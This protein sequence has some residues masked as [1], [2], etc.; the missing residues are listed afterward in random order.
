MAPVELHVDALSKVDVFVHPSA[1]P[2]STQVGDLLTIRPLTTPSRKNKGKDRALLF[3]VDRFSDSAAP[4]SAGAATNIGANADT[5]AAQGQGSAQHSTTAATAAAASQGDRERR[6]PPKAQVLVSQSVQKT[7]KWIKPRTEVVVEV[8]SR[9]DRNHQLTPPPP[10][11]LVA[12]HVEL[13]FNNF[14]LSRPDMFRLTLGLARTCLF[15]NQRVTSEVLIGARLRVGAIFNLNNHHL[16]SAYITDETKIIF[17]SESARCF[18]FVEI[19]QEM[20]HFEEDGSMLRERCEV[21]LD[22]VFQHWSG[23]QR[24]G[25]GG[26]KNRGYSTSHTVSIILYGRVIYE[27]NGEGEEA[28]APMKRHENGTLYRDFFKVIMDLTPSPHPSIVRTVAQEIQRW[29]ES[30]LLRTRATGEQKLAGRIAY[31]HES[32]VLEATNLALNSFEEHW[33]DRDLQRTGLEVLVLTAGT[34]YYEVPKRLLRLTTERMLYHGIGL[35]LISLSKTPL[36]TV[37]LFAFQSHEPG[38]SDEP[39]IAFNGFKGKRR[40]GTDIQPTNVG[41]PSSH[42][43]THS[44]TSGPYTTATAEHSGS[45]H[46]TPQNP[47][48]RDPTRIALPNNQKDPL[49]YD[50]SRPFQET[51]IYYAEPMFIFCSFFGLQV[52]KPHRID[53]FMP[54]A[55]CYELFSQGIGE[56]TPI[57]IPLLPPI[58]A[59]MDAEDGGTGANGEPVGYL[60]EWEKRQAKREM[61]DAMAVGARDGLED[62]STWSKESGA[63]STTTE[64]SVE[65][66]NNAGGSWDKTIGAKIKGAHSNSDATTESGSDGSGRGG[67]SLSAQS[68]R[69]M[70][71]RAAE[72]AKVHDG[73]MKRVTLERKREQE[74]V[75]EK[76]RGRQQR[77]SEAE[78]VATSSRSKTPMPGRP[79]SASVATS[80]RTVS[81]AQTKTDRNK[82]ATPALIARLTNTIATPSSSGSST[83]QSFH[84]SR[85]GWLGLFR[86]PASTSNATPAPS[87][88]VQRVEAQANV[89][90][91]FDLDTDM[92]VTS[93]RSDHGTTSPPPSNRT[94]L[95]TSPQI[96]GP[97]LPISIKTRA[98]QP[99][100]AD[101]P[102]RGLRNSPS[103]KHFT[104]TGISKGK[105]SGHRSTAFRFNPSKPGRRSNGLADQARRWASIFVRHANDQRSVNWVSITRGACLPLT[106]D[107]LPTADALATEYSD[108]GYTV[109]TS[110]T[111][112]S[113]LLLSEQG[114]TGR[115]VVAELVLE[116][117]SQ[118]LSH[119]FQL[120]TP[121]NHIGALDEINVASSKTLPDVLHEVDIGDSTAV[122]L[123]LAN[124]IHRIWYDRRT[125]AVHVKIMRR[126]R[127]W[128]KESYNFSGLIF[129]QGSNVYRYTELEFPYPSMIEP[130]DW[131]HLDRLVAGAERPDLRPSLRFWRTRLVLLPAETVN[132]RESIIRTTEALEADASDAM[133]NDQ[134]FYTFRDLIESARWI[135]PGADREQIPIS[136]T[137]LTAPEW[138][139]MMANN[140]TSANPDLLATAVN[141]AAHSSQSAN[142]HIPRLS[143]WLSRLT[144]T[145]ETPPPASPLFD[146]DMQLPSPISAPE[147]L[148][149]MGTSAPSPTPK[150]PV[151]QMSYAVIVDLDHLGKKSSR[152]E[153]VICH[154]DRSHNRNA[155]YHLE[156]NWLSG[157]GKIIDSAI[158]AWSRQVQKFGLRLIEVSTRAVED[159][160]NPFQSTTILPFKVPPPPIVDSTLP[161]EYYEAGLLRSLGFFLDIGADSSF[162]SDVD[163][164]YSYKRSP[165]PRSQYIHRSGTVLVAILGDRRGL[166]IVA[167]RIYLSHRP[168]AKD[169]DPTQELV[170]LCGDLQKL[171]A[172]WDQLG[173]EADRLKEKAASE[174]ATA[175]EV[176]QE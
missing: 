48:G 80:V 144:N 103:L 162:P 140:A 10:D 29:H 41:L 97:T 174:A 168:Q 52:D 62:L 139:S 102:S 94:S 125:Q 115:N 24:K 143:T 122:Y 39:H 16:R 132:E 77:I 65:L 51:S 156:L 53:R 20:W 60:S 61:H 173:V 105:S 15:V 79:R 176:S 109:P 83:N 175:R 114:R 123:T 26:A 129:T 66:A 44:A 40:A 116:M 135:P 89:T 3:K 90:P 151:V 75:I 78:R 121:A 49:Y 25:M 17:R 33:I 172:M 131:Q 112:N 63:M 150:K 82:L 104:T 95:L 68:S 169:E 11:E 69:E 76:E 32:P 67:R 161:Q 23:K 47:F 55:R 108:F 1:Y 159:L 146:R 118:R 45:S 86:G 124:Q 81:S 14:Y 59:A 155:A 167:N 160:H 56:R 72:T 64:S 85:P 8:L 133:I 84:S 88:A 27:D 42:G 50:S 18:I 98:I 148:G 7:F 19:S 93:G 134:G 170:E 141:R 5:S 163:V 38:L 107:F 2:P 110:S 128:S 22:E 12:S 153:R 21:F 119:G 9:A 171:R 106:T 152:A 73:E 4:S 164:Q 142:P 71:E 92:S 126:R 165:S 136:H 13:Y 137:S 46:N 96:R 6:R 117:V 154:L 120:V 101:R 35:D 87:V 130:D 145:S 157:S 31:A 91:Q 127:T 149:D 147:H 99:K 54:R 158:Q 28:R 57:A 111:S 43:T 113:F 36:H 30:V 166:A 58:N 138:A 70:D 74:I 100:D 34:S 37:P